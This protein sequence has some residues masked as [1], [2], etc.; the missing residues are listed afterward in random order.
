MATHHDLEHFFTHRNPLSMCNL[1]VRRGHTSLKLTFVVQTIFSMGL[2]GV[3]HL[4]RNQREEPCLLLVPKA[5]KGSSV[6]GPRVKGLTPLHATPHLTHPDTHT[7]AATNRS[8]R[9]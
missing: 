2:G 9:W 5:K 4:F 7:H 3:K 1:I 6:K 8:V